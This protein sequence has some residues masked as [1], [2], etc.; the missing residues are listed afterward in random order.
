MA[1]WCGRIPFN[2][3]DGASLGAKAAGGSLALILVMFFPFRLAA[4]AARARSREWLGWQPG[5]KTALGIVL[6]V[7]VRLCL[8]SISWPPKESCARQD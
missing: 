6:Y 4:R 8:A 1:A 2:L 5:I 3:E 7:I